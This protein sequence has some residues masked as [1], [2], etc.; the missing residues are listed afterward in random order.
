MTRGKYGACNRLMQDLDI[1]DSQ[2]SRNYLRI[3][4]TIF[5]ELF[6][7]VSPKIKVHSTKFRYLY[8]LQMYAYE[9]GATDQ[10]NPLPI[11]ALS[12]HKSTPVII[13]AVSQSPLHWFAVQQMRLWQDH[14]STSKHCRDVAM[15]S[16]HSLIFCRVL[17]RAAQQITFWQDK[18]LIIC[19]TACQ[20]L[21]CC[22]ANQGQDSAVW[23]LLFKFQ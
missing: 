5:E 17:Q 12:R 8:Y 16:C 4:S 15:W 20:Q 14:I 11:C 1:R 18:G 19:C 10:S 21:I 6:V 23:V 3:E 13:N 9:Q 2:K 22:T 7:K